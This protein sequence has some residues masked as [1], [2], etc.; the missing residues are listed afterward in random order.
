MK[1]VLAASAV[2]ALAGSSYGAFTLITV[3][4]SPN[5]EIKA[6]TGLIRFDETTTTSGGFSSDWTGDQLMVKN[7]AADWT[8]TSRPLI[9]NSSWLAV[10][11]KGPDG[12]YSGGTTATNNRPMW[13][14]NPA[15]TAPQKYTAAL[16][17][18]APLIGRGA[19]GDDLIETIGGD[20]GGWSYAPQRESL[21]PLGGPANGVPSDVSGNTGDPILDLLETVFIGRFSLTE[22]AAVMQGN[23]LITLEGVGDPAGFDLNFDGTPVNGVALYQVRSGGSVNIFVGEIPAPGALAALGLAGLAGIRRRR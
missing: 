19:L 9:N 11:P 1:S 2:M 14:N 7:A 17:I 21:N 18:G 15:N 12:F 3:G 16:R 10:D 5:A 23:L 8:A 22:S 4:M 20:T 6:S 13:G